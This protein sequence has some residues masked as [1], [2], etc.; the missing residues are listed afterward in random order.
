VGCPRPVVA[1]QLYNLVARK[2]EAEYL[3]VARV[4]GLATMV[5]NPLGGGMLTGR[6]SPEG[7]G[8]GR[9]GDSRLAAMYRERYW[10]DDLF[11]AVSRLAGIAEGTGLSLAELALRWLVTSP[12][13]G[14]LLLGGSKVEHLRQ[15]AAAV[16]AGPLPADV[17]AACEEV[18]AE[19]HGPMP[20]YN[21]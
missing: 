3:E 5:Y 7:A 8:G 15:N 19:L 4:S 9:F 6:H 1:Q 13:V 18:G 21:R 2:V 12:D 10:R 11:A 17:V 20:A 14:A 16:A